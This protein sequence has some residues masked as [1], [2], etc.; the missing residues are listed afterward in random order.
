MDSIKQKEG[1]YSALSNKDYKSIY[2]Y[3]TPYGTEELMSNSSDYAVISSTLRGYMCLCGRIPKDFCG[4]VYV[5]AEFAHIPLPQRNVTL[6]QKDSE[7]AVLKFEKRQ[8]NKY[9]FSFIDSKKNSVYG[10]IRKADSLSFRKQNNLFILEE[11]RLIKRAVDDSLNVMYIVYTNKSALIANNTIAAAK[12]S[13]IPCFSINDGLMAS[14]TDTRPVPRE[15][16]L[17]RMTE[18][19]L[20]DLPHSGCS[21]VLIADNIE[22]PDNLGLIIRTADACGADAVISVGKQASIFHKNCVRASRGAIGRFPVFE[23]SVNEFDELINSLKNSGYRIYGSSA[24]AKITA[25]H[26]EEF[27]RRAF[28]VSNETFGISDYMAKAADEMIKI[29]MATGQS[30]FNVAVAAG[31]ILSQAIKFE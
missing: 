4:S 15:I 31:I 6:T 13:G 11:E 25:H 26:T 8:A 12:A 17:C 18:Y 24:K 7:T 2:S 28:V 10:E 21:S 14:L 27:A 3:K 20:S 30:S 23:F 1:I 22:N 19:K 9:D 16:A 29:P 5:P